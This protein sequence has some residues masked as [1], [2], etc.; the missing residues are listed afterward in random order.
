MFNI[1][2]GTY[3]IHYIVYYKALNGSTISSVSPTNKYTVEPSHDYQPVTNV[4][5]PTV[6]TT[7]APDP[8]TTDGEIEISGS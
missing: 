2:P 4:Q 7:T 8:G 6:T 1:S 5:P 3:D